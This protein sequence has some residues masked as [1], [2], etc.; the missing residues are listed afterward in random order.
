MIVI[1]FFVKADGFDNEADFNAVITNL[2]NNVQAVSELSQDT[3]LS[4]EQVVKLNFIMNTILTSETMIK[5]SFENDQLSQ[6]VVKSFQLNIPLNMKNIIEIYVNEYLKSNSCESFILELDLTKSQFDLVLQKLLQNYDLT[7]TAIKIDKKIFKIFIKFLHKNKD[8]LIDSV[9][10]K[11]LDKIGKFDGNIKNYMDAFRLILLAI[12]SKQELLND[13]VISLLSDCH[14]FQPTLFDLQ[15]KLINDENLGQLIKTNIQPELNGDTL[16]R[17]LSSDLKKLAEE[18]KYSLDQKDL[19]IFC[20]LKQ[21]DPEL[22][23]LLFS[24]ISKLSKSND[25]EQKQAK[26]SDFI[27]LKIDE[28]II[29]NSIR[30]FPIRRLLDE[31]FDIFD[32]NIY[33]PVYLLPNLYDLLNFGKI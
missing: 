28:S 31:R 27:T 25:L 14:C 23:C 15:L 16:N 4:Q 21:L 7:K 2:E 22:K 11:Y 5:G 32:S 19:E 13:Q 26:I 17:S 10:V 3:H 30:N 24:R 12:K 6:F 20:K 33:D 29:N 9:G 18:Y 1:R 8:N